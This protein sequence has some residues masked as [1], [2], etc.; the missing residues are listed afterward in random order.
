[1][2]QNRFDQLAQM[3]P[4]VLT[5]RGWARDIIESLCLEIDRGD[6]REAELE[7]HV[8]AGE[9]TKTFTDLLRSEVANSRGELERTVSGLLMFSHQKARR[10]RVV[11]SIFAVGS[12]YAWVFVGMPG[13]QNTLHLS[14]RDAKTVVEGLQRFITDGEA[15]RLRCPVDT[16]PWIDVEWS[17]QEG[18]LPPGEAERRESDAVARRHL[19]VIKDDV[20]REEV[21]AFLEGPE[22]RH[23][24]GLFSRTRRKLSDLVMRAA[25]GSWS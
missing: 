8:L 11:E 1:M 25:G 3:E 23:R 17:E 18:T 10:L 21:H 22:A 16:D 24:R 20:A 13:Q 14:V 5:K 7:P 19:E 4:R 2:A 15:G 9:G 12:P 6:V